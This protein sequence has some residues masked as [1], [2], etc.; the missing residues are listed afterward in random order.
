MASH[1]EP[2]PAGEPL[3]GSSS[4]GMQR[5]SATGGFGLLC[6]HL[7]EQINFDAAFLLVPAKGHRNLHTQRAYPDTAGDSA[8]GV[9]VPVDGAIREL[10]DGSLRGAVSLHTGRSCCSLERQMARLGFKSSLCVPSEF[11][12]MDA[13]LCLGSRKPTAFEAGDWIRVNEWQNV[14]KARPVFCTQ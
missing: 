13:V 8:V 1:T 9:N 5:R 14:V 4:A 11:R 6:R 7:Q 3:T 12:G 10:L 2:L